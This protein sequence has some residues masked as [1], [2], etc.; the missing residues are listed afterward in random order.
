M[1]RV[2]PKKRTQILILNFMNEAPRKINLKLRIFWIVKKI[3]RRILVLQNPR[4]LLIYFELKI[5]CW[6]KSN[7]IERI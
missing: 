1:I 2:L 5:I 4:Y 7:I 6:I 3:D